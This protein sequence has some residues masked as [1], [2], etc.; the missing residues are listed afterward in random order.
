MGGDHIW[1]EL[2]NFTGEPLPGAVAF[3]EYGLE[4]RNG[5]QIFGPP[6][7]VGSRS[8]A[9]KRKNLLVPTVGPGASADRVSFVEYFLRI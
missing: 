3:F 1:A 7:R 2:A 6:A 4:F 5:F 8:N 9:D